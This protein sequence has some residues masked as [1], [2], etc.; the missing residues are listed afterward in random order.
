MAVHGGAYE[1][2]GAY[3]H[4]SKQTKTNVRTQHRSRPTIHKPQQE[5]NQRQQTDQYRAQYDT[6]RTR[7][8]TNTFNGIE[9]S[10]WTPYPSNQNQYHVEDTRYK[11]VYMHKDIDD[12]NQRTTNSIIT[13]SSN[14]NNNINI[15][16]YIMH[17]D[18]VIFVF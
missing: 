2:H 13:Q 1:S 4:A 3:S 9:T 15:I 16:E 11:I 5:I 18:L 14:I 6:Y 8:S 7:Q 10:A 12:N 17:H